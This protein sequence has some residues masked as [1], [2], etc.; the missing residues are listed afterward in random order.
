MFRLVLILFGGD[1]LIRRWGVFL[2][3]GLLALMAGLVVLI[4]LADGVVNISAHVLGALLLVLGA[5]ELVVASSQ[6][7]LRRRLHLFRGTAL[8]MGAFLVLDFPWNNEIANGGVVRSG[9][10]FQWLA[11]HRRGAADP[12]CQMA[13]VGIVGLRVLDLRCVV[14]YPLAVG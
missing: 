7:G 8:L 12:A 13:H 9:V 6:V 14:A 4:D 5:V 1:A 3:L 11:A 2:A 10:Y